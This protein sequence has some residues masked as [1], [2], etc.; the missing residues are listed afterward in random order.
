MRNIETAIDKLKDLDLQR[1]NGI[2]NKIEPN[3]PIT[4]NIDSL[5]EEKRKTLGIKKLPQSLQ[6]SLEAFEN[7]KFIKKILGKQLVDLFAEIKREEIEQYQIAKNDG[8]E[9]KWEL[10]KYLLL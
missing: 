8:K 4:E 3:T 6:K 9:A 5:T 7:S 2:K 1:Y 10:D